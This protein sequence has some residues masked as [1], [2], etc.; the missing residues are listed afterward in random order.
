MPYDTTL[1]THSEIYKGHRIAIVIDTDPQNPRTDYDNAAKM[2][3]AHG[4]YK[5]G[6]EQYDNRAEIG[7]AQQIISEIYDQF[8]PDED[9]A[10]DDYNQDALNKCPVIWLPL[11][12]YDHSGI[13]IST[14]PFSCPWDSGQ[15]GIIYM[16]YKQVAENFGI[17]PINDKWEPL[18]ETRKKA[19]ELMKAEVKTY[20]DYL[21]GSCYGFIVY[22]LDEDGEDGEEVESCYGF[23][24]DPEGY[25]LEEAKGA[26]DAIDKAST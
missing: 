21:T 15:I 6:D 26:V 8:F 24:C 18:E 22:E 13:T 17:D 20:D 9:M 1:E 7:A 16:T 10:P 12:L 4:R 3:C 23:Y 19:I 2:C 14:A 25:V 5:L 11:Y